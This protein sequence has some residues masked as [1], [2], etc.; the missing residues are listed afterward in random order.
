MRVFFGPGAFARRLAACLWLAA[1]SAQAQ[2]PFT[3]PRLYDNATPDFRGVWE[4]RSTAYANIEGHP[5]QKGIAASK[6][7]IVDPADGKIPYQA[8]ALAKRDENFKNRLSAD[9]NSKCSQAGVPRVTYLPS[10]LQIVQSLGNFAIVY[11]DV[12]AYRIIYLDERPFYERID[13]WMGDS[14][15]LWEGDS[16]VV[17]VRDLNSETWFDQAGNHHSEDMRVIERYTLTDPNTLLYEATMTDSKVFTRPWKISVT[18]ERH[19][20]PGFRIIE[21]ECLEDANGVRRH[22]SPFTKR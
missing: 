16:L 20:E 14:R 3:P 13:W 5:A 18:L 2:K 15:G 4:T 22:V 19:K 9:P 17:D 10:P 11:Q 1:I 12:H 7:I 6:S 21:D 8:W